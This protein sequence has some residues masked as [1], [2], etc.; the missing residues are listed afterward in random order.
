[1]QEISHK[2]RSDMREC[3]CS[4]DTQKAL[5]DVAE[6]TV[7]ALMIIDVGGVW[8]EV[9]IGYQWQLSQKALNFLAPSD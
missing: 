2:N 1:M 3:T 4:K 7:I 5:F 8:V 6:S 9:S